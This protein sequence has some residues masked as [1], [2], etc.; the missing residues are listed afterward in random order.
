MVL[1]AGD[2]TNLGDRRPAEMAS[3]RRWMEALHDRYEC[4]WYVTGNHDLG[5][6]RIFDDLSTRAGAA[7]CTASPNVWDLE[8]REAIIDGLRVVGINLSPCF[9][10]PKLKAAW[11]NMTD[12]RSVDLAVF[13]AL[14][15]ADIVVSHSP[16]F[17][18]LDSTGR[19][20]RTQ[21]ERNI[22]SPGL[23][24]YIERNKPRLV[25]CG[26]VHEAAGMPPTSTTMEAS[27]KSTT[28]PAPGG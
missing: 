4:V 2:F 13:D 5:M 26:H 19:D 24:F 17:T 18:W 10:A 28:S 6:T 15:P 22:G 9:D 27:P 12:D 16:P 25:V 23:L 20:P 3:A 14:P 11:T 1:I 8:G 7:A 21:W